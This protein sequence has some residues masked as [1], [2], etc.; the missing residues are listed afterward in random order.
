MPPFEPS[1]P[2]SHAAQALKAGQISPQQWLAEQ[3]QRIASLNPSLRAYL[4][5]TDDG[6]PA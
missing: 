1:L 6:P 5:Q 3:R 4:S 2:A